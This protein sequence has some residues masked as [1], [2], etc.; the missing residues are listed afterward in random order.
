MFTI[1]IL[2]DGINSSCFPLLKHI[3][4]SIAVTSEGIISKVCE[5]DKI[6]HG[7]LCAAIIRLYAPDAELISVQV[8]DPVTLKGSI[9]QIRCALEWCISHDVSLIN[10][11]IGDVNFEDWVYLRPTITNLVRANIP[12]ICACS[13]DEIPSIFTEF[14][15]PISVER[16]EALWGKSILSTR[17]EFSWK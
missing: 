17:A 15:W 9:R 1:A 2:D 3:K 16:G 4:Y 5:P 6:T 12:L 14:S 13:N 10:L 8:I 7:T 11:S